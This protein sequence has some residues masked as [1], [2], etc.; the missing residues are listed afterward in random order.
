MSALRNVTSQGRP[1]HSPPDPGH[2]VKTR[3][4]HPIAQETMETLQENRFPGSG[5]TALTV[6]QPPCRDLCRGGRGGGGPGSRFYT[7]SDKLLAPVGDKTHRHTHTPLIHA[8]SHILTHER[9]HSHITCAHI[10]HIH[11]SHVHTHTYAHTHITHVHSHSHAYTLVH[12][13]VAV[14]AH[15]DQAGVW[16]GSRWLSKWVK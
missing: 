6:G 5:S 12:T 8:H 3:A 11:I 2:L 1:G 10:T 14:L 16:K 15:M 4:P 9:T 13:H 7:A